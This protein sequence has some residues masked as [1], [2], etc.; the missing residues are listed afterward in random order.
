MI[1]FFKQ[2]T[3]LHCPGV[4]SLRDRWSSPAS[5][6]EGLEGRN[7]MAQPF[8]TQD[9]SPPRTQHQL[10]PERI[11]SIA[12][13]GATGLQPSQ[14]GPE[15]CESSSQSSSAHLLR[16]QCW[17]RQVCTSSLQ[18]GPYSADYTA[19]CLHIPKSTINKKHKQGQ[20]FGTAAKTPFGTPRSHVI[21]PG[22]TPWLLFQ[23]QLPARARPG[24]NRRVLKSLSP[25]APGI[26]VR[27]PD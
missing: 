27:D 8:L 24:R 19:P 10:H 14:A 25:W 12:E 4:V 26:H 20:G 3:A 16:T 17:P 23:F 11:S 21:V 18:G 6:P 5:Y 13:G 22:F 2:K 9:S 15:L 7:A 1:L